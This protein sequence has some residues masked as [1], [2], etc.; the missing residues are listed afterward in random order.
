MRTTIEQH[1]PDLFDQMRQVDDVRQ[2]ASPYE[3]AAH[4]SAC[5]AMFLFKASSRN[6]YNRYREDEMFKRNFKRLFGFGMPHGD[7]FQNVI[8]LLNTD[9]IEA[10][11]HKM[12]QKLLQRKTFH[13]SRHRD[14]WFCIAVDA[15]GVGS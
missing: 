5:L 1:F 14:K 6:Q 7:S 11:K 9:Q 8:A 12:V 3:L 4:L 2:K 13:L 10:L 15:S